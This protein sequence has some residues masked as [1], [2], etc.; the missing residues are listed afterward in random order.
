MQENFVTALKHVFMQLVHFFILL[1]WNLYTKSTGRL[2]AQ[3][4]NN[5]LSITESNSAWPLLSYLKVFFTEFLFDSIVFLVYPSAIIIAFGYLIDSDMDEF[6][7]TLFSA[8]YAPFAVNI[9]RDLF[10]LLLLPFKKYIDW[11]KKPAQHLDLDI[12]NK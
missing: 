8:Y 7:G 6:V 2:A 1:P 11:A 5:T 4:R 9:A 12:R 10:Q 3:A